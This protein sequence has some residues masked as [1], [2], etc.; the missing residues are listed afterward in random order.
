MRRAY[1]SGATAVRWARPPAPSASRSGCTTCW[2]TAGTSVAQPGT[3]E[4]AAGAAEQALAFVRV[5]LTDDARPGRFNAAET[6]SAQAPAL[7]RL[8]AFL[9][10]RPDW[11]P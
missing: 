3:P 4:P 8:A 10:R 9:G 7:D 2:H 5:Q 11:S 6:A 1:S